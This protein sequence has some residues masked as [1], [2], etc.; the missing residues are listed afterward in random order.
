MLL[1]VAWWNPCHLALL[2]PWCGPSFPPAYPTHRS[3]TGSIWSSDLLLQQ[4][5]T[6]VQVMLI[7]PNNSPKCN[8]SDASNSTM[9]TGNCKVLP[10]S[11]KVKVLNLIRKEKSLAE[12][13]ICLTRSLFGGNSEEGK[14]NCQKQIILLLQQQKIRAWCCHRHSNSPSLHPIM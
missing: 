4:C 12:V 13:A 11:E 5:Y 1:R 9:P 8:S 7:S 14:R 10:W 6:C 2:H 3:L